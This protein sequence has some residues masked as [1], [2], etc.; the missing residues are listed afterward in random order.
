M[1]GILP[2]P[3]QMAPKSTRKPQMVPESPPVGISG[4]EALL[5]VKELTES[6][7]GIALR[8]GHDRLVE[9][10]A[11]ASEEANRLAHEDDEF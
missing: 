6:L 3:D 2:D 9:Y 8:L 4:Q 11:L 7:R 5:Y 1:N 10:L